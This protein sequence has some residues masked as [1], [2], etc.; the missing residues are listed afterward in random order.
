MSDEINTGKAI[1]GPWD[2][3]ELSFDEA[4]ACVMNPKA[5]PCYVRGL[6]GSPSADEWV[7]YYSWVDDCWN[8][9]SR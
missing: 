5:G 4:I 6:I 1:G 2:Q 9:H 3:Q 7:G 8:W